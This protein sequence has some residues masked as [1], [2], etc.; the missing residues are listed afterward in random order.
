MEH[1]QDLE[2]RTA[3]VV[4]LRF[5]SGSAAHVI[6]CSYIFQSKHALCQRF[7]ITYLKTLT[8]LWKGSPCSWCIHAGRL[9]TGLCKNLLSAPAES[10]LPWLLDCGVLLQIPKPARELVDWHDWR[11]REVSRNAELTWS[12]WLTL[13][14]RWGG[15]CL[16]VTSTSKVRKRVMGRASVGTLTT[17]ARTWST[18]PTTEQHEEEWGDSAL[19][20]IYSSVYWKH[21]ADGSASFWQRW[22]LKVGQARFYRL[23]ELILQSQSSPSRRDHWHSLSAPRTNLPRISQG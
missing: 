15:V 16:D 19:G 14:Q 7:S 1:L 11:C 20:N 21:P 17:T 4:G 9:K 5:P 12:V 6:I 18:D 8:L 23:M 13:T 10:A 22:I 3:L 2:A